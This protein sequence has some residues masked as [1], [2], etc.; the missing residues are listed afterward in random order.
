MCSRL[1]LNLDL[2]TNNH[3]RLVKQCWKQWQKKAEK[4][5]TTYYSEKEYWHWRSEHFSVINE[6]KWRCSP[7]FIFFLAIS[8]FALSTRAF[9]KI[10]CVD[11]TYD[12]KTNCFSQEMYLWKIRAAVQKWLTILLENYFEFR[13]HSN[14]FMFFFV[15]LF[16]F[17]FFFQI[18]SYVGKRSQY[19]G[20]DK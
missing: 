9:S 7:R 1:L 17:F 5:V 10:A 15:W 13:C 19:I 12:Q 11:V 4:W 18:W 3:K 2:Y 6:Q 14:V 8:V 20:V 16:W